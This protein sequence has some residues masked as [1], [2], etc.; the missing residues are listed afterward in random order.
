MVWYRR[1]RDKALRI[2]RNGN[3]K[4]TYGITLEQYEQM[5]TDQGGNCAICLK[6]E[7]GK[8]QYGVKSLAVDHCHK[9]GKIRGLLCEKC[10]RA[11]GQLHD[12]VD[13]LRRAIDYIQGR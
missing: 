9:T 4:R 12:D 3:L 10:N 6:P 13:V 1:N 5:L 2:R 11:I 8:T 7:T